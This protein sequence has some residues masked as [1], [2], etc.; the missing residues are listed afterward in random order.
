V[1]AA[2]P[3]PGAQPFDRL[4][5]LLAWI[6]PT[7]ERETWRR[8]W[9]AEFSY[10]R[11][12]T[13]ATNGVPGGAWHLRRL[14]AALQHAVWLRGQT[15]RIELIAQDLRLAIRLFA[16]RP[17]FTLASILT[18]ALAIG[19]TTVIFSAMHAVFWRPLPY[20]NP[21]ALMMISTTAAA[22]PDSA[23]PNSVSPP[24]FADWR[25]QST[26]FAE[27]AAVRDD[28]Y[29]LQGDRGAEQITGTAVTPAFFPIF[30]LAPVHGRVLLAADVEPGAPPV[31]VLSHALWQRRFGGD[32][33]VVGRSVVLDGTSRQVV[34]VTARAM[35]YPLD[36]EA[37]TPLAF[38]VDDLTKQRGAHYLTVIGRLCAG[39]DLA[40][41]RSEMA[42]IAMRL[43]EGYPRSNANSTISVAPLRD[44]IV[45]EKVAP[46]MRLLFGAVGLVFLVA[47]VNVSS[48]VLGLALG[49]SRD[50]AVRAALGATRSRLLRG[51]FVES[52]LLAGAGGLAGVGLA[53]L[54]ARAIAGLDTLGIPLLDETRLDPQVI[55]FAALATFAAACL[56]GMLP[57]L[58]ASRDVS[59]ALATG[60][61]STHD[62]AR[63]RAR[64]ALV[65]VE[66][67]LAVALL[68]GAGL[69]ARSFLTLVRTDLGIDLRGVQTIS[70]SLPTAAYKDVERRAV[71]VDELMTRIAARPD[72]DAAGAIFGLPLTD[73]TYYISAYERDGVR[74]TSDEQNALSVNV[75][76]VTPGFFRTLGIP[77]TAGREFQ[78]SDR[79]GAPSV[80]I[81]NESAARLFWPGTPAAAAIG[82]RIVLGTRLGLGGDRAGGEVVGVVGDVRDVG[83]ALLPRP[84]LY[85][86]HAQFPMGFLTVAARAPQQPDDLV[87]WLRASVAAIDP[88][89]PVFRVR[90]MEQFAS[91]AVAQ[92]RLYLALL[93]VFA[94]VAVAL[95][96]IGIYG[97]MAQNVAARSREIGI[98]LALGATRQDVVRMVIRTAGRLTAVGLVVGF[99]V[100]LLARPAFLRV[101][102]G[103]RPLDGPTYLL[104]GL[105]TLAVALGAAWL[106]A[107]RAAKVDPAGSLRAE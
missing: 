80:A 94:S 41:A 51:L 27:M 7:P 30:G 62:R 59:R 90:T 96:A 13:P 53:A 2:S 39:V 25:Q 65:A 93:G 64:G 5:R 37:W 28:G 63:V 85:I 76:V 88:A 107:R 101:L 84:T 52:L 89:V 106:P 21:S 99:G 78:T 10:Y 91:R 42:A 48:L 95:A 47:C 104:V 31:V 9:Q 105:A 49:R 20:P 22:K 44:G 11:T 35:N 73:F 18:L 79:R 56:F 100:A 58:Q 57:A 54:G 74:L 12:L 34:G 97:V 67:A 70:L 61:R 33:G 43:A 26:S 83:P 46:G 8:E 77:V 71:F 36:T 69:L 29:A 19:G 81:L 6:V 40:R 14:T 92:P 24:D 82:R 98:R 103:V 75:R 55:L 66:I 45:G 23:L 50:F 86:A 3:P 1:T 32:A 68:V 72:I 4:L 102:V 15:V 17:G 38:S 60:A 87:N 16:R